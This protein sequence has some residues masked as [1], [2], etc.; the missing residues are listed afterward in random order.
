MMSTCVPR[1]EH[2]KVCV[3]M[4]THMHAPIYINMHTHTYTGMDTLTH[5]HIYLHTHTHIYAHTQC[6]FPSFFHLYIPLVSWMEKKV[7]GFPAGT[8]LT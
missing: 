5:V 4:H 3:G 7:S 2:T 8:E 1:H 6:N